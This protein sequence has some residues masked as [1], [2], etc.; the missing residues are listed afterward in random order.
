MSGRTR[1]TLALALSSLL[2]LAGNATAQT[3]A[4]EVGAV[5]PAAGDRILELGELVQL[6]KAPAPQLA[7][8]LDPFGAL[9]RAINALAADVGIPQ[10]STVA[11]TTAGLTPEQA[12]RIANVL[13]AMQRCLD[14]TQAHF[15]ALGGRG[16]P[17]ADILRT[18]GGLDPAGFADLTACAK[19]LWTPL[20]DLEWT[21]A[22]SIDAG[23]IGVDVDACVV[24]GNAQLDVWPVVRV[25]TT[26][27]AT[28]YLND[29]MLIVDTGGADTYVNNVGGNM[30]DLN[31]A[32]SSSRV[33]GLRGF[34]PAEG[35]DR[36]IPGLAAADCTPTV[37]VLLDLQGSDRFGVKQTPVHDAGC[38][39][40]PLV[41]RL[42]TVG[43][44]FL[45]VSFLVD[46]KQIGPG[47]GDTYTGKTGAVGSGHIF[48]VGVLLDRGGNDRYLAIRNSEGFALV[49][50]VGILRDEGGND[51]YDYYMPRPLDPSAPNQAEGAGGA[52]DDEGD[53]LCD[54]IPRFIQGAANVLAGTIGILV[55][56]GGKDSHRAPFVQRFLAPVN[57]T[58]AAGSW[59]FG[60]NE[61]AAGVFL[62]RGGADTYTADPQELGGFTSTVGRA[63]GAT[64]AGAS[65]VCSPA[66]PTCFSATGSNGG[67]GVFI[68]RA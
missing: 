47:T 8:P 67:A 38:T 46:A 42:V 66:Q 16:A 41:R 37:G 36:A 51:V 35:C 61:G 60:A 54:R 22:T 43:S 62:D 24:V 4:D 64:V 21:M 18:G 45:G 13:N 14:A 5:D 50:G 19:D 57:Q 56:E 63:N 65:P 6:P 48:G 55:D 2:L 31:F 40:D 39:A 53:G 29:Y 68:D 34:G 32:P 59:G 28:T 17:W 15:D 23:G 58:A 30:V 49:G 11:V 7:P 12:G 10:D 20:A 26:C 27:T 9:A 25:D 44:G 33:P 52:R 1:T 3:V